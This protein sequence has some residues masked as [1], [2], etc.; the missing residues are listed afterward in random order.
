M[1]IIQAPGIAE[2]IKIKKDFAGFENGQAN[3]VKDC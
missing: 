1:E 3:K 2:N